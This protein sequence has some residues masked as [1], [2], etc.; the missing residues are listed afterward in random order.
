MDSKNTALLLIAHGSRNET[1]NADFM[2]ITDDL[3]ADSPYA[4]VEAAF[5]ELAEPTI[6]QGAATCV[7]NGAGRVVLVP[8]FLFA[9]VHARNDLEDHRR[10][11]SERFPDVEFR[12]AEPLGR[13]PSLL[14]IVKER[15]EQCTA[16]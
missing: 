6:P 1:A 9:G 8:Y 7:R 15:A 11:L 13:H 10:T 12:L 3:R 4:I 16:E 2:E 14:E 5:L